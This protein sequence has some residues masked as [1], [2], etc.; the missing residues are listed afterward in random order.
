MIIA[1]VPLLL[2]VFSLGLVVLLFAK[3]YPR[4]YFNI[5]AVTF[6]VPIVVLYVLPEP[7]QGGQVFLEGVIVLA[8]LFTALA[9]YIAG[10]FKK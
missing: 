3:R 8:C 9:L 7:P 1:A 4:R 5:L 10:A 2:I 6:L